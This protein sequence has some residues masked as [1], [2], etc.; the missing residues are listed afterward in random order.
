MWGTVPSAEQQVLG[1]YRLDKQSCWHGKSNTHRFQ[2]LKCLQD[3]NARKAGQT[4]IPD[5]QSC[6][7]LGTKLGAWD[8]LMQ[9]IHE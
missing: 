9:L 7:C 3:S 1:R 8:I 4:F 2:A 6:F 5:F